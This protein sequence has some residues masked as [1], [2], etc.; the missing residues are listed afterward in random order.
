[1][2]TVK[3]NNNFISYRL[4]RKLNISAISS[5]AYACAYEHLQTMKKNGEKSTDS[6]KNECHFKTVWKM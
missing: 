2:K 1:M 4:L 5:Q 6:F 3:K